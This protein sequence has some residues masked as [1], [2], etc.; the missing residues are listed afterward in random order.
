[1]IVCARGLGIELTRARAYAAKAQVALEFYGVEYRVQE[2]EP[3]RKRELGS[4]AA[5]QL[6]AFGKVPQLLLGPP[7]PSSPSADAAALE[8]ERAPLLVD[9]ELIVDVLAEVAGPRR[10]P[11][12]PRSDE[13]KAAERH[14]RSWTASSL[15]R[16]LV[17]N[18][19][20]TLAEA[21]E[22]Y[23]YV[24]QVSGFSPSTKLL[25]KVVGGPI[26]YCVSRFVTSRKLESLGIATRD[27]LRA[28]P[29]EPLFREVE[30]WARAIT[31]RG[32]MHGGAMPDLADL[33][34]Y[35][36]LVSVRNFPVFDELLQHSPELRPWVESMDRW[37]CAERRQSRLP[38]SVPAA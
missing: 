22:G 21:N 18:T 29:R 33:D 11:R 34:T 2:V 9:S 20:R 12:A 30:R 13:E 5:L 32:G 25:L 38:A 37:T 16:L 24:E 19:N 36:V 10:R 23:Q 15:V 26:M 4:L 27:E 28:S 7:P 6:P 1:M 14:W 35:G 17:V 3:L 8:H 31:E